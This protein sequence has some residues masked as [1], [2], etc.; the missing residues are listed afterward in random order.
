MV[1]KVKSI[2]SSISATSVEDR[3]L[4]ICGR[5]EALQTLLTN[6]RE[7]LF[8]E[9]LN[10]P[11]KLLVFT[12]S[13]FNMWCEEQKKLDN[14]VRFQHI[15]IDEWQDF[16]RD[17]W[18]NILNF[19]MSISVIKNRHFWVLRDR[20]QNLPKCI[21]PNWDL[22]TDVSDFWKQKEN[23][24]TP[25]YLKYIFRCTQNQL[26]SFIPFMR[27]FSCSYCHKKDENKESSQKF[28]C[29]YCQPWLGTDTTG[30]ETLFIPDLLD[31]V[32]FPPDNIADI[33]IH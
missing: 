27:E 13:K 23:Y 21:K 5:N 33:V 8:E 16:E 10:N 2:L 11:E 3:I 25:F 22:V 24:F 4:I 28:V 7:Y 1:E 20:S 6:S 31:T 26:L 29:S 30:P 12:E 9:C 19:N 32:P 17:F 18:M 14:S 15:F